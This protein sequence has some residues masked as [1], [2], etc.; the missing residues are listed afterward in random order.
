MTTKTVE[1]V[2][3]T[4]PDHLVQEQIERL[5]MIY[6][7]PSS[8]LRGRRRTAQPAAPGAA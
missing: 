3:K 4:A 8:R 7:D 6:I 1:Q 5:R 2:A